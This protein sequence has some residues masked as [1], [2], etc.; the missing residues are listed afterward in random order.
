MSIPIVKVEG[1]A[2]NRTSERTHGNGSVW[3]NKNYHGI[4]S[5]HRVG[6]K[7]STYDTQPMGI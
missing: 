3:G 4:K 1:L 7:M 5:C 6:M 2:N